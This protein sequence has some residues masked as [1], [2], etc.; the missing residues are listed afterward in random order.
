MLLLYLVFGVWRVCKQIY[1][2]NERRI[3]K[4]Q[5]TRADHLI[6]TDNYQHK[7]KEIREIG[8]LDFWVAG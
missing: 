3:I 1:S 2:Q 5:E 7:A 6:L 4:H 8:K